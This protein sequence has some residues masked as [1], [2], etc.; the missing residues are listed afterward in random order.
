LKLLAIFICC[1]FFT[2]TAFGYCDFSSGIKQLPNGNYEYS[3]ECHISVGQMVE[4]IKVKD[5]QIAAL[6]EGLRLKDVA[7]ETAD[8]RISLWMSTAFK[9]EDRV[10]SIDKWR[11]TN[12]TLYF[13]GG[14]LTMVAATYAASKI[15]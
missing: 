7:L 15:D 11:S 13:V 5:E 12:N 1:L 6:T 4:D 2:N 9:L 3:K 8:Q 10:N 14:I